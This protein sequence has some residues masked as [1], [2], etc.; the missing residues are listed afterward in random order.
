[1]TLPTWQP[2][3]TTSTQEELPVAPAAVA[4]PIPVRKPK[5]Q[6]RSTIALLI[7]AALIAVGGVGFALGHATAPASASVAAANAR[8]SGLG[9]RAFASLAP[10]QTFNPT[11]FGAGRTDGSASV[12]GTVTSFDGT[13]LVIAE[14]NGTSVSI[15]VAGTTTYHTQTS[16]TS[17]QVATGAGVTIQIDT[18]APAASAPAPGT[19]VERTLTAKE[20]LITTP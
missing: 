7:V 4:P 20:I 16:A 12:S 2:D 15:D 1:M 5:G 19:S 17:S 3:Q 18:T 14:A 6:D 9:G 13:T 11:Q 10:G 8:P